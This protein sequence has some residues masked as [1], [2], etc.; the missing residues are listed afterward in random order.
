VLP[1][2]GSM[3]VVGDASV[4]LSASIIAAPCG[5]DAEA[6]WKPGCRTV[7]ALMMG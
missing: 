7:W 3:M 2:V 4:A 5:P 6:G 1:E